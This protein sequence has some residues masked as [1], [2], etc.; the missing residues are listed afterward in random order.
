MYQLTPTQREI[1]SALIELYNRHKKM[2]KSKE[3]AELVGKDEGT[4]RNIIIGLKALGLVSSKTGPSGGYIPTLKAYEVMKLPALQPTT[5][6]MKI[7]KD[8][9][10]TNLVVTSI[11]I[12]DPLNP[13]GGKAVF[14]VIGNLYQ[15]RPGDTIKVGPTEYSRLFIEGEVADVDRRASQVSVIVKRFVSIPREPVIALA[16]KGLVKLEP[17]MSLREA[18]RILY[19][20][21]IRGAPVF[22]GDKVVGILTEADLTRAI[23]EGRIESRVRDLMR[24][25]IV[26][27]REDDDILRAIRL[28]NE[29]NVGRLLVVDAMNT[30]KGIITRTDI[31]R[32]IAGMERG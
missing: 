26:T 18:A 30:P 29:H 13:E 25:R 8:G 3:V 9:E 28:M 15:L 20:H 7:Y 23:V 16:S 12:L 2:I 21:G 10:E 1:L 22:E 4:V 5:A 19:E 17:D 14:R 32:R 6:Y 11:E 24:K 31:L 27:I